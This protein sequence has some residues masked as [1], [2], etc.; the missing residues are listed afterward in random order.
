M[1]NEHHG[2]NFAR[3][4][5][6]NLTVLAQRP[7]HP[8]STRHGQV[9]RATCGRVAGFTLLEVLVALAIFALAAIV[10]GSAY[11]NIL[12]SYDVVSRNA[13][14]SEDVAFA[15]QQVLTEADRTKLE[16]GGDFDSANGRRVHWNVDIE[17]AT[18]PDVYTVTF[19][20]EIGDPGKPEPTKTVEK[21]TVLRPTWTVDTAIAERDKLRV[22]VRERIQEIQRKRAK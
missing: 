11:L 5:T 20:C 14:V 8:R 4:S 22:E 2:T 12:T 21:F 18:M 16:K 3:R 15:R 10:L 1:A 19:T 6:V 13:A 9:D 7:R 17:S